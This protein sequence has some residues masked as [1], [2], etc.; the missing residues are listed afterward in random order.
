MKAAALLVVLCST[1]ASAAI[2]RVI[3]S[4]PPNDWGCMPEIDRNGYAGYWRQTQ[5]VVLFVT[6]VV[7]DMLVR[8]GSKSFDRVPKV[9]CYS[10]AIREPEPRQEL[11][12]RSIEW[13]SREVEAIFW[14]FEGGRARGLSSYMLP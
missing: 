4:D 1:M 2:S 11:T 13:S 14:C 8:R 3:C 12:E 9:E 6:P 7:G 5:A 10:D